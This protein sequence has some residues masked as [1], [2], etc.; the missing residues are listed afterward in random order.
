MR[1]EHWFYTIPLR[2]RSI[3]RRSK[4]E[5]ELDEELRLHLEQLIAQEIAAGKT[6]DEARI[7]SLK[8]MDGIERR[9]EECRDM[10]RVHQI[11]NLVGDLRHGLRIVRKSPVFAA[12][13]TAILAL[14]IGANTA[15]FSI[16][17]AVLLRPSPFPHADSLVRIEESTTSSLLPVRWSLPVN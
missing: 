2:V 10:R 4:V 6:P 11:E 13:I 5:Q 3:F 7:A 17:D 1:L 9:K 14:G 16:V 8:A 15:V 12:A